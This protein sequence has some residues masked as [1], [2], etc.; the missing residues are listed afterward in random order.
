MARWN[1][2]RDDEAE[3]SSVRL[4]I[5]VAVIIAVLA[6]VFVGVKAADAWRTS[7]CASDGCV[8]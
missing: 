7:G 6:A 8:Y 5:E 2:F 4:L 1:W 3:Q